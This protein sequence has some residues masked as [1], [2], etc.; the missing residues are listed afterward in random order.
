MTVASE[1]CETVGVSST[2]T[3]ERAAGLDKSGGDMRWTSGSLTTPRDARESGCSGSDIGAIKSMKRQ[4]F[5]KTGLCKSLF[6]DDF[7]DVRSS[8][9]KLDDRKHAD[10]R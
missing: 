4:S 2:S 6:K 9:V 5:E 7:K 10:Q 3:R 8:E 1:Q